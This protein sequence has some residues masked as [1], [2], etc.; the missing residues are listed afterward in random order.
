ME[1]NWSATGA[2]TSMSGTWIKFDLGDDNK[3]PNFII[4][5]DKEAVREISGYLSGFDLRFDDGNTEHKIEPGWEALITLDV[6]DE[7]RGVGTDVGGG[8]MVPIANYLIP[9]RMNNRV[10]MSTLLNV[11]QATDLNW[12]GYLRL[13]LYRK[14]G[15]S[16]RI[17]IKTA[18]DQ[19]DKD[20]APQKYQYE[21]GEWVGVPA[22]ISTGVFV[23]GIEVKNHYPVYNFWLNE[24]KEFY[25]R[26]NGKPY[27]GPIGPCGERGYAAGAPEGAGVQKSTAAPATPPPTSSAKAPEPT[28]REKFFSLLTSRFAAISGQN[29]ED[30][31]KLWNE[32]TRNSNEA[33]VGSWGTSLAE[34]EDE[35]TGVYRMITGDTEGKFV[36]GKIVADG[37]PF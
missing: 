3:P 14:K 17:I 24:A 36:N 30:L 33:H 4:G 5:Q 28:K 20:F 15:S 27:D 19:G 26:W 34:L 35:F 8:Q 31:E 23:S 16:A 7:K 6:R 2:K 18:I 13:I 9:F 29:I 22:S 37:L 21:N 12:D 25:G 11:L 10:I 32:V 1:R